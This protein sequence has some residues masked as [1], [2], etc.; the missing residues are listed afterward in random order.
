VEA[1]PDTPREGI[2]E[3]GQGPIGG[4]FRSLA[5]LIATFVAIA[6]TRLE[7]LT[8]ELQ[9]EIH[10]VAEIMVWTVIALLAAGIGLFLLAL[11][12]VFVF[13]D[14]HRLLASVAV[15]AAFFAI[16]LIA[17]LVLR[18]KLR[19]RPR[20]LEATLAE[21]TTDVSSL[22]AAARVHTHE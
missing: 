15:T 1:G 21:L 9:Q 22:K 14:T 10:R 19:S 3:S 2:L 20:L 11:V 16:A 13:W 8:T 6:R 5:R 17:V 12:I 7:L 4:L 18:A